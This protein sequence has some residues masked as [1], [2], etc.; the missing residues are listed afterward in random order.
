M[1]AGCRLDDPTV[2]RRAS[3]KSKMRRVLP[4]HIHTQKKNNKFIIKLNF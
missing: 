3:Q 4:R 1:S 2:A